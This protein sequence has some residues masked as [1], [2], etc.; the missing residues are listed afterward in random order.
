MKHLKLIYLYFIVGV[1][2][3]ISCGSSDDPID[4]IN[5]DKIALASSDYIRSKVGETVK[6][7]LNTSNISDLSYVWKCDGKQ[8]STEKNP[9]LILDRYGLINLEVT[10]K[11]TS[12]A[13][14]ILKSQIFSAKKT[15]FKSVAYFPSWRAYTG[16]GWDKI[17]HACLCFGEV[18]AN[19]AIN[20]ESVK[21]SLSSVISKAHENGVYVLLSLGGGSE[22]EGFTQALLNETARKKIT[23]SSVKIIE[24]LKLD[25]IDVDYERFDYHQS[26]ENIKKSIELEKLYKE[27]REG[28]PKGSLLSVAITSA[29]IQNKGITSSM[30]QY[31][32]LVNMMIYD[33]TGPWSGS[34]V[35]PHSGWD[36]FMSSIN[37]VKG[38]G[39]PNGKNIAGVP[40]Y[41]YKFKSATSAAGA[42]AVAY[43]DI[44]NQYSGAEDKNEISSAFL[45][46]DGKPMIK[47]KSQYVVDS[48]LGGIMFWEITQDSNIA[49]K[50]L[51]KTI[52]EVLGVSGK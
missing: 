34:T 41:G 23:E 2:A 5:L 40:F 3:F 44:V 11:A 42:E 47:Q 6:L 8:F 33:A 49:S 24:E 50:S 35:G 28:M 45:Y 31:L 4:E 37:A 22:T 46:Y 14:K 16:D 19:G 48:K 27:L 21:K 52:D 18:N 12:G 43:S 25:G 1:L 26:A 51:L 13:T 30:I 39:T 38:I 32:D 17:T 29:Y 9:T 36:Y 20:I 7:E 10:I 15:N